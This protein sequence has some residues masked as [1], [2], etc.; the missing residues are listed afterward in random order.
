[1]QTWT[2]PPLWMDSPRNRSFEVKGSN[3]VSIATTGHEKLRFTVVLSG[4]SDGRKYK[5]MIIF[6]NLKKAPKGKF[7]RTVY[8]TASPGGSMT[9]DLMRD[10]KREVFAKR[11]SIFD[12]ITQKKTG[13]KTILVMDACPA[14]RDK[15]LIGEFKRWNN[16]EV[17]IIPGGCTPLLQPADVV[18][19]RPFKYTFAK[20]GTSGWKNSLEMR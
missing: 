16:T 18:W 15:A 13:S 3:S 20:N 11:D 19:N 9:T 5:P 12:K 4:D 6:K 1:M 8:V 14:H 17:A 10:W 2:K 7:P